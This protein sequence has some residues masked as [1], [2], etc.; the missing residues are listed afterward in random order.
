VG[1]DVVC[2]VAWDGGVHEGRALLESDHVLFCAPD[3]RL[4]I[5]LRDVSTSTADRGRLLLVW[6]GGDAGEDRAAF[7]LGEREAARW[8]ERI[9]HP[10]SLADKLGIKPGMRIAIDLPDARIGP[11]E[12]MKPVRERTDDV[13]FG[14]PKDETDLVFF[15]ADSV[16]EL[17][18]LPALRALLKSNGGIWV[19][20]P[21]GDP[22]IRD[23]DVI[24]AAKDAGLV[25]VKVVRWSETH[26]ALKLVIPRALR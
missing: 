25:D 19:V 4:K 9:S 11:V 13:T 16:L 20:S 21:K 15:E 26:T 18:A 5:P 2:A 8:A 23:V 10:K 7:D 3:L 6:G 1:R 12:F 24:Q 17:A 22:S 14:E